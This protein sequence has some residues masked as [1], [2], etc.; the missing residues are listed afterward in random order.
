MYHQGK[1]NLRMTAKHPPNKPSHRKATRSTAPTIFSIGPAASIA[2]TKPDDLTKVFPPLAI[3]RQVF[4]GL[5][6]CRSG[7]DNEQSNLQCFHPQPM[8]LFRLH[9]FQYFLHTAESNIRKCFVQLSH[10]TDWAKVCRYGVQLLRQHS[11][12]WLFQ[13][14]WGPSW[15]QTMIEPLNWRVVRI[16]QQFGRQAN[17]ASM[18]AF[19]PAYSAFFMIFPLLPDVFESQHCLSGVTGQSSKQDKGTLLAAN[20]LACMNQFSPCKIL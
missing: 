5:T 4:T 11:K 18:V 10:H 8:W 6:F 1:I 9:H 17:L 7:L 2:I 14:T 20:A 13:F 12:V 19:Q 16:F 15:K 3:W